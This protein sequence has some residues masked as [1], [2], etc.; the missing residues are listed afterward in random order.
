MTQNTVNRLTFA[1]ALAMF[2]AAIFVLYRELENTRFIDVV[3]SLEALPKRVSSLHW[4][5]QRRATCC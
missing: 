3:G 5:S 1:V 4:R 2:F